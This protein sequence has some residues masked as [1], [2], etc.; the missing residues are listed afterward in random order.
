MWIN[1]RNAV[2]DEMQ[3]SVQGLQINFRSGQ[4]GYLIFINKSKEF[5]QSLLGVRAGG[6]IAW[7]KPNITQVQI[8]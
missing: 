1:Q 8:N 3:G 7:Q 2:S 4:I 5:S 6:D